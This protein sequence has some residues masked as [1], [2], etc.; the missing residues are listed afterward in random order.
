[1]NVP[2]GLTT[3]LDSKVSAVLR[4]LLFLAVDPGRE[5]ISHPDDFHSRGTLAAFIGLYFLHLDVLL[6]DIPGQHRTFYES[7]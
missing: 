4:K 6:I 2:Q 5:P 3:T 7:M 1:M